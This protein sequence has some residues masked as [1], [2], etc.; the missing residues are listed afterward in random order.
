MTMYL[1]PLVI[2]VRVREAGARG[3]RIW[4]PFVVLWPLLFIVVGFALV[5]AM[6]VDAALFFAGARYYH[7]TLFLLNSL[8]LLA[9]IRGT[10]AHIVS[11]TSLVNVDII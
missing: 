3:F 11:A 4:F 1:P 6:L 10:H 5:V 8:R 2:D 7:Y 9:E